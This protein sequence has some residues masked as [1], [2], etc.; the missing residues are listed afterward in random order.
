MSSRGGGGRFRHGFEIAD[1]SRTEGLQR[2]TMLGER[3][4]QINVVII[5]SAW[6][7]ADPQA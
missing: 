6:L 4:Y 5:T 3:M 7:S 2:L 1:R